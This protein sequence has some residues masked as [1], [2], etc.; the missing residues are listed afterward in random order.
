[1][2]QIFSI[3]DNRTIF[4]KPRMLAHGG[5]WNAFTQ[6][7]MFATAEDHANAACE[8]YAA[9]RPSIAMRE[10]LRE[11]IEDGTAVVAWKFDPLTQTIDVDGL[12]YAEAQIMLGAGYAARRVLGIHPLE[13][14]PEDH[15]SEDD[16]LRE[17]AFDASARAKT[18][19][20]RRRVTT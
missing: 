14:R 18:S 3:E 5:A 19:R 4:C 16:D 8:L 17:A 12:E 7:W 11:M 2:N 15:V 20:S 10:T 13:E 6:A 1:M 9:T